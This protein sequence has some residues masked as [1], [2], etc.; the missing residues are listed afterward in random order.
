MQA[1]VIFIFAPPVPGT[2]QVSICMG[3]AGENT[4]TSQPSPGNQE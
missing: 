3:P 4:D 2:S 1:Y